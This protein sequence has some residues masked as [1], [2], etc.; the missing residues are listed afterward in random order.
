MQKH[1]K[2]GTT[3]NR[4]NKIAELGSLLGLEERGRKH[5]VVFR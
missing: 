3:F 1:S 2:E 5:T 4:I